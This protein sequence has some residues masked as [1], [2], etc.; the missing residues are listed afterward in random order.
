MT[1]RSY[2]DSMTTIERYND[3]ENQW[4]VVANLKKEWYRHAIVAIWRNDIHSVKLQEGGNQLECSDLHLLT[5]NQRN[6]FAE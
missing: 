4:E 2:G 5:I 1:S 6:T 3:E